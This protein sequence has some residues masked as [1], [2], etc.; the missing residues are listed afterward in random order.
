MQLNT[1]INVKERGDKFL[2]N[3]D[4]V[5]LDCILC[6]LV[7]M[8]VSFAAFYFKINQI[9]LFSFIF[10]LCPYIDYTSRLHVYVNNRKQ[11]NTTCLRSAQH[12]R[13]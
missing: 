2:K 5:H 13:V 9:C 8:A 7:V 3:G 1:K 4:A 10:D 12:K 11:T 6:K